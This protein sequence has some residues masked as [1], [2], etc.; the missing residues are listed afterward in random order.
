MILYSG[1]N[2]VFPTFAG[3][4]VVRFSASDGRSPSVLYC[5]VLYKTV[6]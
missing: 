4:D 1:K 5:T 3:I 6:Q 2:I